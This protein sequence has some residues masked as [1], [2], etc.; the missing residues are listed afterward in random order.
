MLFA[1]LELSAL[2][3]V[4]GISTERH[5][6]WLPSHGSSIKVPI[7]LENCGRV[8]LKHVQVSSQDG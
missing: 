5:G 4:F 8:S 6:C 2:S 7:I 1:V 3:S